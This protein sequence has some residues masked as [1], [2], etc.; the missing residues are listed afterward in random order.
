MQRILA[1]RRQ[2]AEFQN[3]A[4]C[5]SVPLRESFRPLQPRIAKP[6]LGEP[7]R[8]LL[9]SDFSHNATAES[10]EDRWDET[11]QSTRLWSPEPVGRVWNLHRIDLEKSEFADA[12]VTTRQMA[13]PELATLRFIGNR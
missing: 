5:V 2:D 13:T 3:S 7:G 1:Q 11:V 4:F 10:L 9:N 12:N 6:R 8:G